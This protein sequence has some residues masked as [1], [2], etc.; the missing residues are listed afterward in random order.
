MEV[1]LVVNRE[2]S[3]IIYPSEINSSFVLHEL[4]WI[5]VENRQFQNVDQ[6]RRSVTSILTYYL[7][8]ILFHTASF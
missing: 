5:F 1:A 2:Q 4:S 7:K 8:C 6:Y 3:I